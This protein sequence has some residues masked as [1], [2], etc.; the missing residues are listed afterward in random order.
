MSM[1]DKKEMWRVRWDKEA[2]L[3]PP[4]TGKKKVLRKTAQMQRE[5]ISKLKC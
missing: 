5:V 1:V 4:N 2:K 3:P